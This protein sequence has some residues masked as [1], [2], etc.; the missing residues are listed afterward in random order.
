MTL[1]SGSRPC[2]GRRQVNAGKSCE[3]NCEGSDR[4]GKY[5][6]RLGV[7]VLLIHVTT[8]LRNLLRFS[9]GS[10]VHF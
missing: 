5:P 3:T 2:I 8:F 6:E 10:L 4:L 9:E 7:H 1:G